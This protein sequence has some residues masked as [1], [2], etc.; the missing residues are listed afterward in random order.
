MQ[1]NWETFLMCNCCH[2]THILTF[3]YFPMQSCGVSY[4][5]HFGFSKHMKCSPYL[6]GLNHL[7]AIL[8]LTYILVL[9]ITFYFVSVDSTFN[10]KNVTLTTKKKGE[11]AYDLVLEEPSFE[12]WKC[13]LKIIILFIFEGGRGGV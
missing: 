2:N 12:L 8:L 3:H 10:T 11:M 7:H 5:Q 9:P 13:E 4:R 6:L 1:R